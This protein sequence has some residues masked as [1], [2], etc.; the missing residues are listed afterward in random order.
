MSK[1]VPSSSITPILLDKMAV[2]AV[3]AE[4]PTSKIEGIAQPS[5]SVSSVVSAKDVDRGVTEPGAKSPSTDVEYFAY[6]TRT[7]NVFKFRRMNKYILLQTLPFGTFMKVS[8]EEFDQF[9]EGTLG[10]FTPIV[11]SYR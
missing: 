10:D 3:V 8:L 7:N 11:A 5:T 9:F 1:S 4:E 2:L 6:D